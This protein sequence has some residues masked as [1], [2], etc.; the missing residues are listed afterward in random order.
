MILDSHKSYKKWCK[1]VTHP[2]PNSPNDK[3]CTHNFIFHFKDFLHR[4]DLFLSPVFQFVH[5]LLLKKLHF[6]LF[7]LEKNIQMHFKKEQMYDEITCL[8]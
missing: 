3:L 6:S 7:I 8:C 2:F 5:E 4:I 1:K